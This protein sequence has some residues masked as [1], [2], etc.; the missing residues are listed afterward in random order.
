VKIVFERDIEDYVAFSRVVY[1]RLGVFRNSYMAVGVLTALIALPLAF[2]RDDEPPNIYSVRLAL[3][4]AA[5]S[6][7]AGSLVFFIPRSVDWQARSMFR[8]DASNPVL[9]GR[10]ELELT[11]DVIIERNPVL[12]SRILWRGIQFLEES[13]EHFYFF[14]MRC[15]AHIVPKSKVLEGDIRAFAARAKELWKAAHPESSSGA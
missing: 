15:M 8:E 6:L 2:P 11:E 7:V 9:F 5:V 13:D 3:S 14:P 4:I 12:E 10:Q 1:R